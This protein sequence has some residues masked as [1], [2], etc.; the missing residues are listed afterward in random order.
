MKDRY[1]VIVA[2]SGPAGFTAAYCAARRGADV[3]LVERNGDL[4]GML[5]TGLMGVFCGTAS[6]GL[7]SEMKRDICRP[8][9]K[10]KK[11]FTQQ[12]YDVEVMKQYLYNKA[13]ECGMS[14]LLYAMATGVS[15]TGDRIDRL[16][17]QAKEGPLELRADCFIDATGDGD[18]AVFAGEEFTLG[19][20]SDGKFQPVT[21]IFALAGVDT[22]N[23]PLV[24]GDK[25]DLPA[26]LREYVERGDVP[27]PAGHVICIEG[28]RPGT[29]KINMTNVIDVDGSRSEEL[30]QS[31]VLCRKQLAGIVQFLRQEAEGFQNCYVS[32]SAGMMGVR[33]SR[34]I[35][36]RHVLNEKEVSEGKVFDDWAVSRA[37]YFWGTHNLY[38]PIHGNGYA[39]SRKSPYGPLPA[40]EFYTIPYRSLRPA[41]TEN[42]LLAGRCISGTFLAHSNY[43]VMPICMAMGQGAGTAA[44]LCAEDGRPLDKLDIDR[45][46]ETLVEDG[47]RS[48]GK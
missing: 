35:H 11:G 42:L 34:H 1:D 32:A 6:S 36:G 5:T 15:K 47:V 44:A 39:E 10:G 13:E 9:S 8:R 28:Y 30:T 25:G 4:G 14:L 31:E 7:F 43:R 21:L 16:L 46:H 37:K 23:A 12:I 41:K 38:G 18:V 48:P 2:G 20:E 33:S 45:F 40:E 22:E 17:V 3:L 29:V 24:H 19:R 26:K 27:Y